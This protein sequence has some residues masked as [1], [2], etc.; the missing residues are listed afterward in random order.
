MKQSTA[1]DILKTGKNVFLTGSAGAGKTYTIN[2]YLHYLRVRN[3]DVAVTASTGIAATHMNGMTIHSWSGIGILDELTTSDINR[4]KRRTQ[5]VERIQR[6]KV[7]VI[8][9]ISMLHLKQFDMINQMLQAV[10]DNDLPFGGVQLLVAGDFFQLPPVGKN[11]ETNREKFAFMAKSWLDADFAVCYLTEQHRQKSDDETPNNTYFGL[12]LIAILNQIRTQQFTQDIIPALLATKNHELNQSRTRLYTHNINV[13]NIND[14][15]LANLTTEAKLFTAWG[16]GDE[17]LLENLKKS[18]RTTP[19]LT[20]KIGAK[21]MFIKNNND[22]NVSNGTMGTIVDFQPTFIEKDDDKSK[23]KKSEKNKN[24]DSDT[25]TQDDENIHHESKMSETLFPVVLLNDG[26]KV[27]A[28]YDT[29]KVEDEEGEILAAYYHIPLTLAWAIT[30]HKSQGMTLD[31]AEIDLSKTFEKG[32]GYV[33]LSR[34]KQLSGL[35]LLGLNDKSLQLDPTARGADN[36]FMALSEEFADIFLRQNPEKIADEQ[37]D[38]II[39]NFG[40][41]D[42]IRIQANEKII[43]QKNLAL[44]RK[45]KLL[46]EKHADDDGKLS[47]TYLETKK[48][49]EENLS[50][51]EIADIRNLAQ[52]TIMNHISRL[53]TQFSDLPIEHIRSDTDEQMIDNVQQAYDRIKQRDKADDKDENGAIKIK[54]IY[55]FLSAKYGYNEI[56]LAL[57]FI[58]K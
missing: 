46:A 18:V 32:Q 19:E 9:E 56:R 39:K 10:K 54:P 8:D 4:V 42:P 58:E 11:E 22:L 21:V 48:L 17:K 23:D 36:R 7:L 53:Q 28:E 37:K 6:T 41:N 29:W 15:E 24:A 55:D 52:S 34:L 49:L 38:F 27:I 50:I 40:T 44:K 31:S 25:E 51:A 45:A 33:A 14:K 1:L 16:E 20:L 47:D 43:E 35:R 30:I 2:Q 26:R 57:L 5:L 12:D 13:Q 3:I